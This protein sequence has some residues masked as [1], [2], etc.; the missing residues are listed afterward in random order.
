M[1]GCFGSD[2]RG[3]SALLEVVAPGATAWGGVTN[4]PLLQK[5]QLNLKFLTVGSSSNLKASPPKKFDFLLFCVLLEGAERCKEQN[6][7]LPISLLLSTFLSAP[8]T[9]IFDVRC[10][11]NILVNF[12]MC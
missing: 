6:G 7:S 2:A 4:K 9:K 11:V 1:L 12:K 8:Q 10:L 3:M 5:Q